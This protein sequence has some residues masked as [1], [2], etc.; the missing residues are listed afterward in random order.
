MS[1]PVP[2]D[3][4]PVQAAPA[5]AGS[6]EDALDIF[7]APRQVFERRRDGKYWIPL[8]ILCAVS[9]AIYF[10]SIQF[11]EAVADAEFSRAM[12]EQ[13]AKGGQKMTAEQVA[14]AKA[15]AGKF[16]ALVVYILPVM[17]VISA[18]VSGVII[19]LLGNMMG[20]KLN[21]AQGVTVG[22]LANFPEVL[23]RA[24]VGVQG[25]FLDTAT[26]TS[27]YA[28][29]TS[30]ARFMS[31]DANKFLLKL[32]ALADPFVIW[33]SVLVGIGV[34]V[35]GRVEKEKAAVLAIIHAIG[36]AIIAR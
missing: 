6:W 10:L 18:W 19:M 24:V 29:A 22:V 32:G 1:D 15:F 35:I 27:K 2:M 33:S 36:Y 20:G 30:V 8:L 3:T 34:F 7:Y 4:Q 31:A 5:N 9:V 16:K 28:F 13:A 26:V 17:L 21:F 14:A 12:A 11:N 23:G 25:L